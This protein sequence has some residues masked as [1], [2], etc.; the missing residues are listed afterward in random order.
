MSD[1]G[2]RV[3]VIQLPRSLPDQRMNEEDA[4]AQPACIARSMVEKCDGLDDDC[5]HKIDEGCACVDGNATSCYDGPSDT[6]SVG[7]CRAGEQR[8][9]QGTW[10]ACTGAVTPQQELCNEIDDDCDGHV[11]EGFELS[12]DP[13]HCGKC[14]RSCGPG[15]TCCEG[16]CVDLASDAHHCGACGNAC[17]AGKLPGCCDG[18][19]VDL[20]TDRTCGSC[21]NA[22]GLL[23]LGGGFLCHCQMVEN[24]PA[25]VGDAVGMGLQVCR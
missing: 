24:G 6:L 22:C 19:C 17:G 8:C 20:L 23:K 12:S 13:Q 18:S 9:E 21:S 16:Q 3:T 1:A 5:D 11:D 15:T 10:R 25:C 14:G 4:G 7:A 2:V